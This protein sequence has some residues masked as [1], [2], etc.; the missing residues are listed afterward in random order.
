MKSSRS[1][2]EATAVTGTAVVGGE[3]GEDTLS[4]A[5]SSEALQSLLDLLGGMGGHAARPEHCLAH[6]YC[7]VDHGVCIDTVF[8]QRFPEHH[9]VV[10]V[11]DVH[12]ND[13][14]LRA[15]H[16]EAHVAQTLAPLGSELVQ[17]V[18]HLGFALQHIEGSQG[19]RGG[20]GWETGAED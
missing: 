14:C 4:A 1:R 16:I 10:L 9:G 15:A 13:R 11:A 17:A 5:D 7:G 2:L 19:G 18:Y 8:D 12:R 3:L 6:R 20:C